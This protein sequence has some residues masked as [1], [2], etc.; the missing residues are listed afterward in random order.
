MEPVVRWTLAA[1][2]PERVPRPNVEARLAMLR[3]AL[4]PAGADLPAEDK[5]HL[6]RAALLLTSPMTWLYWRD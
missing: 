5:D 3:A 1:P 2:D 4:G 6:L